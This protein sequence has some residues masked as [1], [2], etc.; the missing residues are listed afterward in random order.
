M[1]SKSF[2]GFVGFVRKRQYVVLKKVD[3]RGRTLGRRK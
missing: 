2:S 1:F 3:G